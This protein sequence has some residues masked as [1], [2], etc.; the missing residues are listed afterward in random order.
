MERIIKT[1]EEKMRSDEVEIYCLQSQVDSLKKKL[2]NAERVI[3][4]QQHI[5]NQLKGE[6]A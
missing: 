6:T 3:S 1:I 4:E 2:E 5:I